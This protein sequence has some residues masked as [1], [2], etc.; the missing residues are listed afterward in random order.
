[1]PSDNSKPILADADE[2]LDDLDDVLP[3]FSD[4]QSGG[5]TINK[6]K[7]PGS[8]GRPRHNT[9]VDARPPAAASASAFL[10]S[11]SSTGAGL[12][13][14]STT[15]ELD[16]DQMN[17]FA[18]E[19][20]KEMENLMR[21]I[22][23][24]PPG[25][26]GSG[27]D[28]EK[29]AAASAAGG[30]QGLNEESVKEAERTFKAAWEAMLVEEMNDGSSA[31]G[32][33]VLPK[34]GEVLGEKG[35]GG[36]AAK[37]KEKKESGDGAKAAG[38]S[39]SAS[40]VGDQNMNFQERLKQAMDKM[41]E[42]ESNLQGSQGPGDIPS[43]DSLEAM[44]GSLKELGLDGGED[45]EEELAG[46]LE[47]MMDQL[48]SKEVLYEP[49]KE[50]SD[51]FPGYLKS[52]PKPLDPDDRERYGKQQACLARILAV[53]DAPDYKDDKADSKKVVMELM[54]EMQSYGTPPQELMGNL[55][56]GMGLGTDGLPQLGD[57][58]C[59]IA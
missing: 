26:S 15:E 22:A 57:G 2:D 30:E 35:V 36:G 11:S 1:M 34:L 48:L 16:E 53:F 17:E 6:S 44:F 18:R 39:A 41:K 8:S 56:P 51:N 50:L 20:A 27:E 9:R 3:E 49:L 12:G 28:S 29:K 5:N 37:E 4:T 33:E 23:P 47:N 52:P 46:F 58:N 7:D 32:G 24:P 10:P 59:T 40:V 45:D 38:T 55:P 21:E 43:A 25:G 54:H 31:G 14:L 19:L 13:G 42:S